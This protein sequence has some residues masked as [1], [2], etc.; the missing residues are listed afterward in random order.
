MKLIRNKLR[1]KKR[2]SLKKL[3]AERKSIVSDNVDNNQSCKFDINALDSNDDDDTDTDDDRSFYINHT[4]EIQ[5]DDDGND[6]YIFSMKNPYMIAIKDCLI[7]NGAMV[8]FQGSLGGK[9]I[10]TTITT[11]LNAF[12]KFLCWTYNEK[13]QNILLPGSA[14]DWI[15]S[16]LKKE[17]ILL[18]NYLEHMENDLRA[19]PATRRNHIYL[20]KDVFN[21]YIIQYNIDNLQMYKFNEVFKKCAKQLTKENKR[22]QSKKGMYYNEYILIDISLYIDSIC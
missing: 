6:Q 14:I 19:C 15:E 12:T 18:T 11:M 22:F 21:W 3:F 10:P 20:F 8:F 7:D 2:K 17:Y 16:I 4:D 9:K 5:Y 1:H 13:Y